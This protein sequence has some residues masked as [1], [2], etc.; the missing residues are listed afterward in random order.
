M[1][2]CKSCGKKV[3]F[4]NITQEGYCKACQ[5]ER[6][7]AANQAV[8]DARE[9]AINRVRAL[10]AIANEDHAA[11]TYIVNGYEDGGRFS[12]ENARNATEL[13]TASS[14]VVEQAANSAKQSPVENIPAEL[15]EA[16]RWFHTFSQ[17]ISAIKSK[18]MRD[19]VE[20]YYRRHY[21]VV[22]TS[23]D[24]DDGTSRQ[25]VL[26]RIKFGVKYGVYDYVCPEITLNQYEYQEEPAVSVLANG[27]QIG[28]ISKEDVS[29]FLKN[30]GELFDAAIDVFGGKPDENCGAEIILTYKK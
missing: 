24:N 18:E 17:K 5:Q 25:G 26:R 20:H 14:K 10:L 23:F 6:V 19:G 9:N 8:A 30:K 16:E 29:A 21:H 13:I 27:V 28:H 4:F 2:Q 1:A 12:K 22:G 7:R 3:S 11:A 15:D